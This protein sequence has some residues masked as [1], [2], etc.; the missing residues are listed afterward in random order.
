VKFLGEVR[1][2]ELEALYRACDLLVLPSVTRQE[3]FGV[4]QIEAMSH[5]KPVVCTELGTGVGW[6]NQDGETGRVVPPRNPVALHDAIAE[7]LS[8]PTQLAAMGSSARKRARTV[9]SL[10]RMIDTTIELYR[11]VMGEDVERKTVA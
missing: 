3:A 2:V 1:D 4:V 6:V 11:Q 8:K 10:D 7:L 5:G 9:F